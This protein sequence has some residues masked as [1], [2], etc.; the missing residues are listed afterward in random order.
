MV[1]RHVERAAGNA[2]DIPGAEGAIA[3]VDNRSE[4]AGHCARRTVGEG[5]DI[6]P[7]RY[8][9]SEDNVLALAAYRAH[10]PDRASLQLSH[11][12]LAIRA[13]RQVITVRI[14]RGQWHV[15]H[16]TAGRH[17]DD[18]VGVPLGDPHGAIAAGLKSLGIILEQYRILGEKCARCR[19]FGHSTL[20]NV[21]QDPE[22]VIG[23]NGE[24]SPSSSGRRREWD[25][26]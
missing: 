16:D 10:A 12:N 14:D 8:T 23:T 22:I 15:A 25:I 13:E 11:P 21:F 5:C 7:A 3:P 26:Q 17:A 6:A 24:S 1:T 2:A 19:D 9:A 20:G 4:V 18:I